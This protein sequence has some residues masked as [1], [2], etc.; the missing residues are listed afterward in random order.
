ML[1]FNTAL[2]RRAPSPL[3]ESCYFDLYPSPLGRGCPATSGRVRGFFVGDAYMA[4]EACDPRD[5]D[6]PTENFC[7]HW[8]VNLS[9][10]PNLV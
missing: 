8:S 3:G 4:L 10:S 7:L 2:L 6:G 1:R 9:Q 5:F